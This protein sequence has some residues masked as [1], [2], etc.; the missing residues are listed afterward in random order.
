MAGTW[1]PADVWIARRER[2]QGPPVRVPSYQRDPMPEP[3]PRSG[4]G[5]RARLTDAQLR[6]AAD[7]AR[8]IGVRPAAQQLGVS[9]A[10][11]LRDWRRRGIAVVGPR[12]SR[13]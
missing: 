3:W 10:A 4:G 8:E 7:L 6:E 12:G 13:A 11:L 2:E 5:Y 9:H 1:L